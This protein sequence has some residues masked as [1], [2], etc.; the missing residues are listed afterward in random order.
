[1]GV[2]LLTREE[3]E[4]QVIHL[5]AVLKYV[6]ADCRSINTV[7]SRQIARY[8]DAELREHDHAMDREGIARP[9]QG[10]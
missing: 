5:L 1:M 10:S 3:L 7:G 4:R 9:H 2:Q 6:A 8:I